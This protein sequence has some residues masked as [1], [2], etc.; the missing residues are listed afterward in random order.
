MYF[1]FPLSFYNFKLNAFT[2]LLKTLFLSKD[3]TRSR[4]VRKATYELDERLK[5]KM[6]NIT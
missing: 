4:P 2:L 3:A 5:N 1:I 6:H